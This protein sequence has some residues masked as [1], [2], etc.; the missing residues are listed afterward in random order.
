[1][2]LGIV[3]NEILVTQL[4]HVWHDLQSS[5]RQLWLDKGRTLQDL[6]CKYVALF[7]V[8]FM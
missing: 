4:L 1:M 6:L 7:S 2:S 5:D 8:H 3:L